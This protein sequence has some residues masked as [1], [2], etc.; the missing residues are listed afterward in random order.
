MK[1]F[2]LYLFT[3]PAD[4]NSWFMVL[5]VRLF[6]GT[7]LFFQ[8][9]CLCTT[10]RS[11]SILGKFVAYSGI[12]LGNAILYRNGFENSDGLAYHEHIHVHQHQVNQTLVFIVCCFCALVTQNLWCFWLWPLGSILAYF[13]S[14]VVAVLRDEQ[15]Y[16]DNIYEESAK[17]QTKLYRQKME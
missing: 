16:E 13:C 15:W 3:W 17:A 11:D 12:T 8:N 14:M 10:F 6:F 7:K 5:F 2:L 1:N 9:G 4:L